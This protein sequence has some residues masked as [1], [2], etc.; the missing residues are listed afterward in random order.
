MEWSRKGRGFATYA[1]LRQLGK[2]GVAELIDRTCAH[3]HALVTGIGALP[4][5]EVVWVLLMLLLMV[6]A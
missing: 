4:G 2:A 1:A 3:A 5:A 6:G